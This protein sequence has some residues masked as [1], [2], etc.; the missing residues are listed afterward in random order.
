MIILIDQDGV[1]ADFETGFLEN[2]QKKFPGRMYIPISERRNFYHTLDYP[3]EFQDDIRGI[4]RTPG[5]FAG[6]P[7][8][9][10]AIDAVCEIKELGHEVFICTAPFPD[11]ETCSQEKLDWIRRNLGR[12]FLSHTI[13]TYDKTLVR[14]NILIDDR[15]EVIGLLNSIWEHIVFDQPYN[16]N[17]EGKR[18]LNWK[19]W[20]EVL[21]LRRQHI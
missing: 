9:E 3:K 16:G 8:M 19:N 7:V 15:G 13:I 1:L 20:R 11:N 21:R 10:G 17:V 4:F 14:G 18:R 12:E 5:F 2:W 6:L